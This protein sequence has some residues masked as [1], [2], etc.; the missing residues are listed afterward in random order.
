[1]KKQ[2]KALFVV[3]LIIVALTSL[4]T[5]VMATTDAKTAVD[6]LK[7][8]ADANVMTFGQK[9]VPIVRAIGIIAAVIIL[10]IVGINYMMGSAE[11]KADYKKTMPAYVIGAI[12]VFAATQVIGFIIDISNGL[13]Q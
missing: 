6:Q 13:V 3:L 7:G 1:M 5:V 11:E 2:V 10:M 4:T 12:L 8:G 9:I